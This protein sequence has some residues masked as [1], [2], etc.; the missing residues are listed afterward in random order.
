MPKFLITF[1]IKLNYRYMERWEL[2]EQNLSQLKGIN[3]LL[4]RRS[5]QKRRTFSFLFAF[6]I[7]VGNFLLTE[8]EFLF[9]DFLIIKKYLVKKYKKL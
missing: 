7:I 6:M 9:T 5:I 2:E 3:Y 4:E 8:E 1:N